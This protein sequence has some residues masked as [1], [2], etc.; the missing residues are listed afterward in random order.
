MQRLHAK[1]ALTIALLFSS[2]AALADVWWPSRDLVLQRTE[3]LAGQVEQLDEH[4]HELNAPEELIGVVHHFEETVLTALEEFTYL[5]YQEARSEAQHI[6]EDVLLVG[7]QL[8]AVRFLESQKAVDHWNGVVG[9]Y[10]QLE[11]AFDRP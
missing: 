5:P 4:L 11:F 6:R 9:A 2:S 1:M 3:A 10:L 7:E 8:M